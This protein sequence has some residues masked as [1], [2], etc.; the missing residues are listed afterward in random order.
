MAGPEAGADGLRLLSGHLEIA[1]QRLLVAE[2]RAVTDRAPPPAL[3]SDSLETVRS[4][5]RR[6]FARQEAQEP[7]AA[8]ADNQPDMQVNPPPGWVADEARNRPGTRCASRDE[9]NSVGWMKSY[10]MA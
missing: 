1:A 10:S 3:L 4:R 2:I 5:E 9:L 6:T 7:S 8:P